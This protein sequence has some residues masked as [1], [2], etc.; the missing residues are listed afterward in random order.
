MLNG[1]T[2]D[3]FARE[4]EFQCSTCGHEFFT[5]TKKDMQKAWHIHTHKVCL[6][7]W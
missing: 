2:Y 6:G 1:M 4:W 3:F 7:G 5:P